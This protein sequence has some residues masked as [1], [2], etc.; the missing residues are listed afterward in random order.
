MVEATKVISIMELKKDKVYIHGL[1]ERNMKEPGLKVN[2]MV[3]ACSQPL[4][5]K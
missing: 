4:K 1:M 2:N 5:E 3:M